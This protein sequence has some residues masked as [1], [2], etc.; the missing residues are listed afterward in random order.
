M[1]T[2]ADLEHP[3]WVAMTKARST[4]VTSETAARRGK[5]A[6]LPRGTVTLVFT[7]IEGSVST[8]A[9][10]IGRQW[11][12]EMMHLALPRSGVEGPGTL[13]RSTA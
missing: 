12:Q 11:P 7:D 3:P 4:P 1:L 6:E 13:S 5:A 2:Y 9:F 8:H 10:L